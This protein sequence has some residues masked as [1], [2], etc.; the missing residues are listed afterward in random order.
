MSFYV[1]QDVGEVLKKID[2]IRQ[3]ADSE[4]SAPGFFPAS[5]Y[6][7]Q[8]NKGNLWIASGLQQ[9]LI[10]YLLFGG[11]YPRLRIFQLFVGK[12]YR[13]KGVGKMLVDALVEFGERHKYLSA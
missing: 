13:G 11:V 6:E 10:G 12:E 3:A 1:I 7:E 2:D 9:Q 5:V 8:A 4:K